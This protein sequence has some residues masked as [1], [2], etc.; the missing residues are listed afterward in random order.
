MRGPKWNSIG[1]PNVNGNA[2]ST[3]VSRP[4]VG[5]EREGGVVARD[6]LDPHARQAEEREAHLGEPGSRRR[7]VVATDR[8]AHGHDAAQADRD[9]QLST[10]L[11]AAHHE[12]VVHVAG[13]ARA[14]VV[15]GLRADLHLSADVGD[16]EE[17]ADVDAEAR[18][19]AG[20]VAGLRGPARQPRHGR[21]ADERAIG[22][23]HAGGGL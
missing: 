9:V 5:V 7:L 3:V 10:A 19:G 16:G 13:D 1:A 14:G 20:V 2:S 22:G 17:V 6:S 8:P 4:L 12:T 18:D 23:R 21:V 15:A 11:V